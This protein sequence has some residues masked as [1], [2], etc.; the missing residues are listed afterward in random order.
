MLYFYSLRKATMTQ[1]IIFT[2]I[3][4]EAEMLD[5]AP[6][7]AMSTIPQWYKDIPA[8]YGDGK[9]HLRGGMN[10]RTVKGCMPFL[11]AM[12]AGYIL[13]LSEDVIVTWENESPVFNW[14]SSREPISIHTID[15]HKGVPCPKGYSNFVMKFVSEWRITVPK[16]YSLLC[17]QPINKFDL[18]FQ[19]ITGFVDAD[20]FP[21]SIQLPFFIQENWEGV[22]EAGT[23]I[24]QYIPIKRE[25]WKSSIAKYD[26]DQVEKNTWIWLRKINLS[27]KLQFWKR[28]SYQ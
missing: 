15:Q 26:K 20:T 25:N 13:T 23:P 10:N 17:L 21:M 12:T 27:Y 14:R 24:A 22:I 2:P 9:F 19:L 7:P 3:T 6:A 28:K 11:D 5:V 18:P 1:K 4:A 16:G 8:L